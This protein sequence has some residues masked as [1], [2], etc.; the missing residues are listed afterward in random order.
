MLQQWVVQ[1]H[2]NGGAPMLDAAE[3]VDTADGPAAFGYSKTA[4]AAQS[5]K[6]RGTVAI[7][8]LRGQASGVLQQPARMYHG[9][10]NG[11]EETRSC[12]YCEKPGHLVMSCREKIRDELIAKVGNDDDGDGQKEAHWI[13]KTADPLPVLHE[14]GTVRWQGEG[15]QP[16]ASQGPA[17][18]LQQ[19]S[20]R[21]A[22]A[23]FVTTM[24]LNARSSDAADHCSTDSVIHKPETTDSYDLMKFMVGVMLSCVL[25]G[26]VLGWRLHKWF[27]GPVPVLKKR[28]VKTQSQT[29]YSW[30]HAT[31]RFTVV[32]DRDQGAFLDF[33]DREVQDREITMEQMMQGRHDL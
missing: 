24:A 3:K 21:A 13:L 26:L 4:D 7:H 33:K 16:V 29:H 8:G 15:M 31:P 18:S 12:H 22:H 32:P 1:L 10:K 23:L 9:K 6:D 11:Y 14:D 20:A 2:L 30:S 5:A 17:T 28:S 19:K 27:C 25:V